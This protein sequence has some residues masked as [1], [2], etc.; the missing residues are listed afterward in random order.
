MRVSRPDWWLLLGT[1]L[2]T[3]N[4]PPDTELNAL[5]DEHHF[6][7][8]L[9]VILVG[10]LNTNLDDAEKDQSITATTAQLLSMANI[11]HQFPSRRTSTTTC[12]TK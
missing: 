6:N 5:E 7:T 8:H 1:Y 12:E 4:E 11:F 2:T 9:L 10:N 3:P